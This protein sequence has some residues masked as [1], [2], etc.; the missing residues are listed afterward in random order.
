VKNAAWD[1]VA[2]SCDLN[3]TQC[4]VLE[5]QAIEIYHELE[6]Q[7]HMQHPNLWIEDCSAQAAK[8]QELANHYTEMTLLP[9]PDNARVQCQFHLASAQLGPG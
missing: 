9:D 8:M 6:A 4:L 1:S 2:F 3:Q 7:G 5:A